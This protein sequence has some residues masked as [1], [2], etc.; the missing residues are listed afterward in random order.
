MEG[1]KNKLHRYLQAA[2]GRSVYID[3]FRAKGH[4]PSKAIAL[5]HKMES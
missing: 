1:L 5:R 2:D 4:E 3:D